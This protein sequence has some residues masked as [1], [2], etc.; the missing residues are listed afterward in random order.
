MSKSDQNEQARTP[1]QK[2]MEARLKELDA[3]IQLFSAQAERMQADAQIKGKQ[4][5]ER[6]REKRD[7]A[8]RELE[9]YGNATGSA[10][11]KIGGGLKKAVDDLS[12]AIDDAAQTF[13]ESKQSGNDKP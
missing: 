4:A 9:K 10:L 13:S 11:E 7:A 1:T 5:V 2:K 12:Q 3:R 6:L 8:A